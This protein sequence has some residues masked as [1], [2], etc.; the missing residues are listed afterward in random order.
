MNSPDKYTGVGC[1]F[2]LLGIFLTGDQIWVSHS[3]GK[4][5]TLCA[6]IQLCGNGYIIY[7][8]L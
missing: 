8:C 5:S 4:F 3:V 1:H 2:F 7:S 6:I